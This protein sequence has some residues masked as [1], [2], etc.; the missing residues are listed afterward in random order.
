MN[1][2]IDLMIENDDGIIIVD[3]KTDRMWA[4]PRTM[5]KVHKEQVD[6]Y[7]KAAEKTFGKPV[8]AKY[9]FLF[10]AKTAVEI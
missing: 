4:D 1:G 7:A 5:A 10:D 9:I 2:V 3:Y 8:K 6:I